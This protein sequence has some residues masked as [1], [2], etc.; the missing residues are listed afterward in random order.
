M[1]ESPVED[2]TKKIGPLPGYAYVL[3]IAVVAYAVYYWR[4]HSA[5]VSGVV[6]QVPSAIAADNSASPFPGASPSVTQATNNGMPAASTNAIWAANATNVLVGTG[7]DPTTVSNA[8]AHYLGGQQLSA[9]EQSIINLAITHFGAPPEGVLPVAAPAN[10]P[11]AKKYTQFVQ[12]YGDPNIYG[13]TAEGQQQ[14]LSPGEYAALGWP[15]Y[16]RVGFPAQGSSPAPAAAVPAPPKPSAPSATLYTVRSGDS[17]SLIAQRYYGRTDLWTKLYDANK[18]VV[19]GN[20]NL[21]I[22]GQVLTVPA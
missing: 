3:I 20:P 11:L 16:N 6:P 7:S 14:A 10:V 1:S 8:L 5:S 13:I 17:L 2:L 18:G 21:I 12:N 15:H 4:K 19:G 22:P 9:S